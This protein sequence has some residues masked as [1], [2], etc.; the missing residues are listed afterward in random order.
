MNLLFV[1]AGRL[2]TRKSRLRILRYAC[3]M[4]SNM[5]AYRVTF[6]DED[7]CAIR[8]EALTAGSDDDAIDQIGRSAHPYAIDIHDGDRLVVR[9]PPWPAG[10][11]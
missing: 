9:F 1:K 8:T 10:P 4:V 2:I 11:L 3:G 7:E 5:P 6:L